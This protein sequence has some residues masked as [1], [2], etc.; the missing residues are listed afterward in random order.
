MPCWSR[1]AS[2]GNFEKSCRIS[3]ALGTSSEAIP[4]QS[5][6]QKVKSCSW[7]IDLMLSSSICVWLPRRPWP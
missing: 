5:V 2:D 1:S 3:T 7:L 4:A 6:A